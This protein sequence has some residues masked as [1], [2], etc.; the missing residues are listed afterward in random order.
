MEPETTNAADARRQLEQ[1]RTQAQAEQ[2]NLALL[3]E[4]R[5]VLSEVNPDLKWRTPEPAVESG[6]LCKKPFDRVDGAGTAILTSGG[7]FGAI[8]DADWPRAWAAVKAVAAKRG[9]GDENVLKDEPGGHQVSVYD[10]DG[11]ELSVGTGVNTTATVY[12]ACYLED[13]SAD[14]PSTTGAGAGWREAG[15]RGVWS[16]PDTGSRLGRMRELDGW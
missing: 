5:A 9:Y 2:D 13:P 8:S 11:S 3:A 7:A 15:A 16:C 4:V 12:G 14:G 1:R 10:K 6:S